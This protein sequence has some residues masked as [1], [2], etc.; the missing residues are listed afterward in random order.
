MI[1]IPLNANPDVIEDDRKTIEASDIGELKAEAQRRI[2]AAAD[3]PTIQSYF[4]RQDTKTVIKTDKEYDWCQ[5]RK[6][7]LSIVS[8]T[9]AAALLRAEDEKK[10][11]K[12]SKRK[13]Q[14]AARK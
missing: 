2:E 4:V 5:S 6:I 9:M 7:P 11:K 13:K 10:R 8:Y 1:E 3:D 12:K 14:K